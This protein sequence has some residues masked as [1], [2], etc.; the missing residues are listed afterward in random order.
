MSEDHMIFLAGRKEYN[1]SL[2]NGSRWQP[3]SNQS[4]VTSLSDV[5]VSDDMFERY[6]TSSASVDESMSVQSYDSSVSDMSEVTLRK[7]R[8]MP[9]TST[10]RKR[11]GYDIDSNGSG[12]GGREGRE[13]VRESLSG[14]Q[15]IT[16]KEQVENQSNSINEVGGVY[17][18]E[19]ERM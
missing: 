14:L 7:N 18:N 19:R 17:C 13:S 16:N 2:S 9:S 6:M 11:S 1:G 15:L 4:D 3:N 5:N 8:V 10:P 12:G